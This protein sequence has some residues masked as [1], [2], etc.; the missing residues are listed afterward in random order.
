MHR[1]HHRRVTDVQTDRQTFTFTRSVWN[2]K[3]VKIKFHQKQKLFSGQCHSNQLTV[4]VLLYN[5]FSYSNFIKIGSLRFGGVQPQTPTFYI[6]D[7]I[8]S[9]FVINNTKTTVP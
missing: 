9:L 6:L 8:V 7:L 4:S 3:Y 5:I 1:T 2:P